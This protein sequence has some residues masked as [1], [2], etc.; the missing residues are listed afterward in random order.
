[1][2]PKEPSDSDPDILQVVTNTI[3]TSAQSVMLTKDGVQSICG[4]MMNST[5]YSKAFNSGFSNFRCEGI[6]TS[7]NQC[8]TPRIRPIGVLGYSTAAHILRRTSKTEPFST[9]PVAHYLQSNT[10]NAKRKYKDLIEK[11]LRDLEGGITNM[12]ASGTSYRIELTFEA[13][14]SSWVAL[15]DEMNQKLGYIR[16]TSIN[17]LYQYA[18]LV[19]SSIFPKAIAVFA[20]EIFQNINETIAK[21]ESDAETVTVCEKEFVVLLENL[22][23]VFNVAA[24][25]H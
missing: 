13:E 9:R 20:K 12:E 11:Q 14:T 17:L 16:D 3:P 4:A 25:L 8:L 7:F 18:I 21:L 15:Q 6:P 2:N 19:P 10:T 1:M 22:V 5:T 24:I 23:Y